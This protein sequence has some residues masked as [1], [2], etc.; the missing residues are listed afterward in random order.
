MEKRN[1]VMKAYNDNQS[2]LGPKIRQGDADSI[3]LLIKT[4]EEAGK[5]TEALRVEWLS[6]TPPKKFLEFHL[7]VHSGFNNF[8]EA[9]RVQITV[10]NSVLLTGQ[11]NGIQAERGSK[12]LKTSND[13][14]IEAMYLFRGLTQ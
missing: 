1:A 5:N 13:E 7:L 8:V 11:A 10:F 6:L 4:I 9:T 2:T 12:L 3:K 14:F